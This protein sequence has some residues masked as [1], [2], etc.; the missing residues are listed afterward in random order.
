MSPDTPER[1]ITMANQIAMFF[2]SQR[3]DDPAAGVAL[4]L[5]DFWDPQMRAALKQHAEAGGEGL[6]PT[7]RQAA[8][9]L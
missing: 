6:T 9:R 2:D 3:G 8:A 1:L 4:H 7:A 5:R